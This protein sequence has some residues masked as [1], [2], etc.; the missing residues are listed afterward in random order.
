MQGE[1]LRLGG[2][3][4]SQVPAVGPDSAP[5]MSGWA[6]AASAIY[7]VRRMPTPVLLRIDVVGTGSV[8]LDPRVAGYGGG[9]PIESLP[10]EPTAIRVETHP[11]DGAESEVTEDQAE[12]DGLMWFIG[13]HAFGDARA[14]W[15]WPN[16]RYKITRW[17]GVTRIALGLDEIRLFAALATTHLSLEELAAAASV[18]ERHAQRALNALSLMGVLETSSSAPPPTPRA[19]ET[20]RG[21]TRGL[22]GRLR[23]RLGI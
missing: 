13:Q 3:A 9:V 1:V 15:L 14:T 21:A 5:G 20:A 22:F 10:A 4:A 16:D 7:A 12:F 17:P 23:A 19:P 11:V 6:S 18:D 2:T 8:L